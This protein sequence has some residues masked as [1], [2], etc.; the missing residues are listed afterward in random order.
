MAFLFPGLG[1]H[2]PGMAAGLYRDEPVFRRELDRAADVLKPLL[3][4]DLRTL[5]FPP[6]SGEESTGGLDLRPCSAAVIPRNPLAGSPL[7]RTALAQPALFAVEL[8]L[9]RL[10]MSW[11]LRP[12]ALLGYS[13]GEYVAACV[14]GVLSP[15]DALRVVAERARLIEGLPAGAMLAVALREEET[16]PLLGDGLSVAAGLSIAAVNGPALTVVAGV[17][18]EVERLAR[19]LAERGIAARTLPTTHAFH[20]RM[21][22]PIAGAV[23][24]VLASVRLRAPEIPYVS[25]VTGTWVTAQ[26][27]TDPDAWV[28]HMLRPVRFGPGLAE[29][30]R[31]PARALLEVGPGQGLGSLALQHPSAPAGDRIVVSSLRGAWEKQPD[32]AVLLGALGK[33]WIAGCRIDWAGFQGVQGGVQRRRVPLPTYPFERQRYW[34]GAPS[35]AFRLPMAP[36]LHEP[37]APEAP[38]GLGR[39]RAGSAACAPLAP[40][41]VR[42][43]GERVGARRRRAVGAAPRD[44]RDRRPR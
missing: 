17:P 29:L 13:L 31:D 9:A 42:R 39:V 15:D 8:A 33:L 4:A 34:L 28:A 21:M 35:G 14:A 38:V 43:A 40:D 5:L 16:A 20:S 1:D 3:G 24:E 12:A 19:L 6:G 7:A 18:E 30:W 44:R 37:G 2:Y 11:G 23:R 10:W 25:N 22:E 26:E 27:A 36:A 32:G 41:S